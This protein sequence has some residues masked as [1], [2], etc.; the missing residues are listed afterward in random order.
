MK[1][2]MNRKVVMVFVVL[3]I[4]VAIAV[5]YFYVNPLIDTTDDKPRDSD[6]DGYPDS[7]DEF[8]YDPDEWIDSDGDGTGDNSDAFPDNPNEYKDEDEDGIGSLTDLL[9]SGDAGIHIWVDQYVPYPYLDEDDSTPDPYFVIKV[10][11]ES[12]G[13]LDETFQSITYDD[14]DFPSNTNI[15]IKFD[16]DDDLK[17]LTFKIEVWDEDQLTADETIDYSGSSN[18]DWNEHVLEL[19]AEEY[20]KGSTSPYTQVYNSDGTDD[21]N[22]Q[23]NDCSLRYWIQVYEVD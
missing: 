22:A 13:T 21:G 16:V 8:P 18:L 6:A 10:D 11:I 9:D 17:N 23:E 1:F 5:S 15:E 12:D 2:E 3:I 4:C 7:E 20:E 14:G 19:R